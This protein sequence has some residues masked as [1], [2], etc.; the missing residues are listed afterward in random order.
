M[1]K[2]NRLLADSIAQAL[3]RL[4]F[5]DDF[6][7]LRG[8]GIRDVLS[9]Q[10]K[11]TDKSCQSISTVVNIGSEKLR[12]FFELLNS[13]SMRERVETLRQLK[14]ETDKRER[15]QMQAELKCR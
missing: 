11:V 3:L 15:E 6:D 12:G 5:V 14:R 10:A 8:A 1:V 7:R 2:R 13:E 4:Y 9:F